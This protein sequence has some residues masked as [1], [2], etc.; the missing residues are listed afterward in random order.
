MCNL[1]IKNRTKNFHT[2]IGNQRKSHIVTAIPERSENDNV[3]CDKHAQ[4]SNVILKYFSNPFNSYRTV[5]QV[6]DSV[7]LVSLFHKL[8]L[9]TI[10]FLKLF[11]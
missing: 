6:V 3:Q 10:Y 1:Y 2:K 8:R 4:I 7:L 9:Y 11:L 5:L